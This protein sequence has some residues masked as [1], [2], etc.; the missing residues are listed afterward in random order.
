MSE[1]SEIW[2]GR[3]A[4]RTQNAPLSLGAKV[5]APAIT[6]RRLSLRQKWEK[7]TF[8]RF[9]GDYRR[10]RALALAGAFLGVGWAKIDA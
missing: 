9:G 4:A 10:L 3:R 7:S 2:A 1:S 8:G 5:A 6:T